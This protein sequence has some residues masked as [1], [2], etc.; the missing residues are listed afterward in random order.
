MIFIGLK[1]FYLQILRMIPVNK[2]QNYLTKEE[3]DEQYV[4]RVPQN[5]ME[6]GHIYGKYIL[7]GKFAFIGKN[8]VDVPQWVGLTGFQQI[9][10]KGVKVNSFTNALLSLIML[11]YKYFDGKSRIQFMKD[12]HRQIGYDMEEMSLYRDMGYT[13]IRKQIRESFINFE[14]LDGSDLKQVIVDYFSLTVYVL[15][16][17]NKFGTKRHVER[18]AFVPQ[19]W[20]K[21]ERNNEFM[22]KNLTCILLLVDGKYVPVV[23][24]DTTGIFKTQDV[25]VMTV[26][27]QLSEEVSTKK[28]KV[29]AP[30]KEVTTIQ[31][32]EEP[33]EEEKQPEKKSIVK[34]P[35]KITLAAIQEIAQSYGIEITK[36]GKKTL[37][38]KTIDE[39][40]EEIMEKSG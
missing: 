32:A 9:V 28:V 37:L 14:N 29:V 24:Q 12:L 15:S 36:Q 35:K 33:N 10:E 39:L 31:K 1:L 5:K 3:S 23:R 40:R 25:E 34:I 13:R 17:V 4:F 26:F 19:S 38:K 11:E 20:K 22:E 18:I 7:D 27:K 16:E 6:D 30:K 8:I 21:T 2:L